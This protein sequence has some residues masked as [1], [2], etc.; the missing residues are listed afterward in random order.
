M[1]HDKSNRVDVMYCHTRY[2]IITLRKGMGPRNIPDWCPLLN[3]EE[4]K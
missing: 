1:K 3:K 2:G 4:A